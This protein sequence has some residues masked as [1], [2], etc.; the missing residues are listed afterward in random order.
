MDEYLDGREGR[1][2]CEEGE[3]KCDVC[4]GPEEEMEEMEEMEEIREGEEETGE[5][6]GEASS[7]VEDIGVVET[8]SEERQRVFQQ[9]E[10]ERQGP[11]QTF[12]HQRQQEFGEVEWLRRQLAWWANRCG[13]CDA[14]GD[15]RSDHNI[16]RC[17]RGSS[18]QAREGIE[19]ME[20]EIK[21]EHIQGVFGVEYRRRYA[22]DGSVTVLGDT[23][24]CEMR[25]VS[26]M[27]F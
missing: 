2:G 27:G 8:E 22:A 21:F 4:R 5:E 13:I 1:V 18:R 11:R 26:T 12:I 24:E 3:E 19:A 20:K 15:G 6:R 9:Q 25:V 16:R 23:R 7:H 14:A 10:Q 17:W